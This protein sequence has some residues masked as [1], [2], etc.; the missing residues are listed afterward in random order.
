M[1]VI[2]KDNTFQI[3][4]N[5]QKGKFYT[6]DPHKPFCNCPQ[7]MYREMRR[8]GVCKHIIAVRE[9]MQQQGIEIKEIKAH[10]CT[11]E[12]SNEIAAYV[13]QKDSVDAVAL[14]ERFGEEAVNDLI[15]RGILSEKKGKIRCLE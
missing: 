10:A 13:K 7:F 8:G 3:E 2:Y 5:S 6:I 12:N 1:N 14:I 4:S 15:K 9:Y 11:E